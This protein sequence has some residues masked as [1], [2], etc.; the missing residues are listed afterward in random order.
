ML[1][2]KASKIHWYERYYWTTESVFV[3]FYSSPGDST[4]EA[5]FS[6]LAPNQKAASQAVAERQAWLGRITAV[7]QPLHSR[8]LIADDTLT[9]EPHHDVVGVLDASELKDAPIPISVLHVALS[10]FRDRGLCA[11]VQYEMCLH[12]CSWG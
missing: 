9:S 6:C 10:W 8:L 3:R 2:W 1:V 7:R 4:A 12:R 5:H 11:E